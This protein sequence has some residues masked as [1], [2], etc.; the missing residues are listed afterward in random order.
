MQE[1][2]YKFGLLI[3]LLIVGYFIQSNLAAER[4][5]NILMF[6]T[7]QYDDHATSDGSHTYFGAPRDCLSNIESAL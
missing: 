3:V 6:C 4:K 1:Y 7:K 5:A 2:T